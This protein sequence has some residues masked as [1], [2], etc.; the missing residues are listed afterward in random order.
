MWIFWGP[1]WTGQWKKVSILLAFDHK[2]D[3]IRQEG[4]REG[5]KGDPFTIYGKRGKPTTSTFLISFE[6]E[7][8]RDK[9]KP[10]LDTLDALILCDLL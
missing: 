1:S 2:D 6:M 7:R 8:E 9:K 10:C 4:R 3:G 5:S